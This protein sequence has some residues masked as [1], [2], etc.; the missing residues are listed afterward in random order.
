[1]MLVFSSY[2]RPA[3]LP[4]AERRATR[5][6]HGHGNFY[7]K[8]LQAVAFQLCSSAVR[9][10]VYSDNTPAPCTSGSEAASRAKSCTDGKHT[11]LC[12]LLVAFVDYIASHLTLMNMSR[13]LIWSVAAA[14]VVV[15]VVVV[16]TVHIVF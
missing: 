16:V 14:V 4:M 10:I 9:S 13:G 1:M 5:S 3:G 8:G 2:G 12:P 11:R 6:L 15:M 7:G